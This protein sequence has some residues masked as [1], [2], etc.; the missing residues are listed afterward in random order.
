MQ[1]ELQR[2]L[3]RQLFAETGLSE[4]DYGVLVQ[5]SEAPDGQLRVFQLRAGLQW[6]K[7]RLT[8][9]LGR[10]ARRGL[11]ERE[12]CVT[13]PRGAFI[14]ITEAG[15]SAITAAA[16]RHVSHVRR[17][18]VDV[19]TPAQLDALGEISTAVQARFDDAEPEPCDTETEPYDAETDP[20]PTASEPCDADPGPCDE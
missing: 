13:D 9:H 20:C 16:P 8:H 10:M 12:P 5:L 4:A 17:W 15:Q 6:E 11:V 18:F 14:R 1:A 2:R 19:L 3:S 7:T